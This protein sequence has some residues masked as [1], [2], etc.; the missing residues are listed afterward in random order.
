[1]KLWQF[2]LVVALSWPVSGLADFEAGSKAYKAG[3]YATA[4]REFQPLA[5]Q[6]NAGA[7]Y[8]LGV[9]Y[10]KGRGVP[11][12]YAEAMKWYRFAA[13]QGKARAQSILG[14]MY[15]DG[16]GVPQDYAEAVKWYRLAA[17]QGNAGAQS[18]L[19]VM[20]DKGQGV[21][22]DYALAYAWFNLAADQGNK[23]AIENRDNIKTK[24][25]PSQIAE[26]QKFSRELFRQIKKN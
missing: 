1:M 5:K 18:N 15:R 19:G 23:R 8:H 20:Y 22:Q 25:P 4:L 9:M 16:Q 14:A 12:D 21:L 24:M 2:V 26:G 3:D 7:Q 6:G 11:Q 10:R 13:K 17:K